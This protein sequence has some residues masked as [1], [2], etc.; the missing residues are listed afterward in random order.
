MALT[1]VNS[2][3]S[4][5]QHQT[6]LTEFICT[7]H[8][9]LMKYE[10]QRMCLFKYGKMLRANFFYFLF[11]SAQFTDVPQH[12]KVFIIKTEFLIYDEKSIQRPWLVFS[13]SCECMFWILHCWLIVKD[14]VNT[15]LVRVGARTFKSVS[16]LI[17]M[18][19]LEKLSLKR[20]FFVQR[21]RFLLLFYVWLFLI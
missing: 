15:L 13:S 6:A 2:E 14:R 16:S 4:S 7:F 1:W 18:T 11:N 10:C 20:Q 12:H 9:S 21:T 5:K 17:R 3:F 19:F 8:I